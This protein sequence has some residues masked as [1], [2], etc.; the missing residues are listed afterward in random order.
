MSAE[1]DAVTGD[2]GSGG[3]A[4]PLLAELRRRGQRLTVGRRAVVAIVAA[5]DG[6]SAE[7][8]AARVQEA[9]PE[10]HPSTVYRTLE[11]L[12]DA[13]LV[14][15]VHLGHGPARWQLADDP[16]H[17]L[18]CEDCGAVLRVPREFFDEM[19][20]RIHDRY[21]FSVEFAHFAT[22]GRCRHCPPAAA[23]RS[24]RSDPS[25]PSAR[26]VVRGVPA[27]SEVA[28]DDDVV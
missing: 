8:I 10:V 9:H 6:L 12:E 2:D 3:T 25:D 13:G 21:G 11:T 26:A 28:P 19:R 1:R 4:E 23:D 16:H 5:D 20:H 15:H 7:E 24:D 14:R 17:H 18:V 27:V 22:V